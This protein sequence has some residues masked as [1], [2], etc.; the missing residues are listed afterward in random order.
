[1]RETKAKEKGP[2]GKAPRE[3]RTKTLTVQNTIAIPYSPSFGITN[4]SLSS[5]AKARIA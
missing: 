4:D 5:P 1:L 3:S 2:F